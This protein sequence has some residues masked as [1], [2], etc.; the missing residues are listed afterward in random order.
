MAFREVL[1]ISRSRVVTPLFRAGDNKAGRDCH[2]ALAVT[3]P[4]V[5]FERNGPSR[6]VLAMTVTVLRQ[7]VG[8]LTSEAAIDMESL[9]IVS[10]R[11]GAHR[12]P[13]RSATPC[14]FH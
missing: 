10:L 1:A 8:V 2:A 6:E 4:R 9:S 3:R 7:F 13:R 11:W 14:A 12:S 5:E